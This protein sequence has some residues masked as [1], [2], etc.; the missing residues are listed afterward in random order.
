MAKD[1]ASKKRKG[2]CSIIS[3]SMRPLIDY[4]TASVPESGA[5]KVKKVKKV[6]VQGLPVKKR[7]GKFERT[8]ID[9][10]GADTS[11]P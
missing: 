6:E 1:L 9:T 7:K 5:E 8:D 11:F 10:T 4:V 2:M 3:I